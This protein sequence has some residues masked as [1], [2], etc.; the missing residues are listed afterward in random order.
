MSPSPKK[1]SKYTRHSKKNQP[2]V[3]PPEEK[4]DQPLSGAEETE[5]VEQ[6]DPRPP[7]QLHR[8]RRPRPSQD[9]EPAAVPPQ[10]V[11]DP[12]PIVASPEP[13]PTD[14]IS[15]QQPIPPPS[16]PM[17]YRAIGL[18]QGAYQPSQDQ[19]NRGTLVTPD[20]AHLDAV[21]LG[22]V[23]SLV[24]KYLVLE[25]PYLWVVY[26]RTRDK[27]Q[28]LHLQIVGVWSAEGFGP[29]DAKAE[30][31]GTDDEET[32]PVSVAEAVADAT[33]ASE[34]ISAPVLTEDA[35][36]APEPD[37]TPAETEDATLAPEPDSMP[38]E[39]EDATAAS[40]VEPNAGLAAPLQDGYFS[41][42]GEVIQQSM[43]DNFVLIKIQ[44]AP[45]KGED[46]PKAFK[47]KLAGVLGEKAMGY[48]WD[49]HVQRVGDRLHIQQG[50]S[51]A[52]VPPKRK[53]GHKK[54][55][56]DSRTRRRPRQPHKPSAS[57]SPKVPSKPIKRSSRPADQ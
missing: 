47:L 30:S 41:I 45:R 6:G 36:L 4:T 2:S 46:R 56:S 55:E 25:Q 37:S 33:S 29:V 11:S 18:V 51:I 39:T 8:P 3:D 26:P 42:R 22:Q 20:G 13:P 5:K 54:G 27:E 44:Q 24:K 38:A 12:E 57:K 17:Q 43:E 7:I 49:L 28:A 14:G 48:F 53:G 50:T 40:A 52:L 16:E 15:G 31:E 21:L 34:P 9:A 1:P 35:T 19:F 32:V 23:M 10:A